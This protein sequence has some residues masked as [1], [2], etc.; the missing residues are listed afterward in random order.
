MVSTQSTPRRDPSRAAPPRTKKCS[1]EC[2]RTLPL[3]MFLPDRT[4]KS[5]LRSDCKDCYRARRGPRGKEGRQA[6][7]LEAELL[8]LQSTYTVPSLAEALARVLGEV[9]E[10]KSGGAALA[11]QVRAV[12]KAI[13]VGGCCFIDEIIDDTGLSRWKVDRAVEKLLADKVIESRTPFLLDEDAE[14]P[15]R[16]SI[17]YHPVGSPRGE[18][19]SHTLRRHV[20]DNLL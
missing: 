3:S 5:G 14:E 2:G 17:Q 15:G 4:R 9:R 6:A 12:R 8:K 18:D 20:E 7:A 16:R 11:E 10:I 13:E 19:F 1:G